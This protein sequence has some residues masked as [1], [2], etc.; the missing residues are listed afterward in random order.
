MR[1]ELKADKLTTFCKLMAQEILK[2]RRLTT[3]LASTVSYTG[4]STF[5]FTIGGCLVNNILALHLG[6]L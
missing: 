2:P 4:S 1:Q 6:A 3:L 5:N